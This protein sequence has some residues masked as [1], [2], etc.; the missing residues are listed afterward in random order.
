MKSIKR[1][2]HP[3]FSNTKKLCLPLCPPNIKSTYQ[4]H[5]WGNKIQQIQLNTNKKYSYETNKI[6]FYSYKI[7]KFYNHNTIF[8]PTSHNT[9]ISTALRSLR[10]IDSDRFISK[11]D[12]DIIDYHGIF[13]NNPTNINK[14]LKL[15]NYCETKREKDILTSALFGI[16]SNYGDSIYIANDF[17][18]ISDNI[19][20]VANYPDLV[21]AREIEKCRNIAYSLIYGNY[22]LLLDKNIYFEGEANIKYIPVIIHENEQDYQLCLTYN[23]TRSSTKC[24]TNI[25]KYLSLLGKPLLKEIQF[26]PKDTMAEYFYH[27]DCILN[28]TTNDKYQHFNSMDDFWKNYKKNG[29]IAVEINGLDDL[30]Y[31]KNKLNNIFKNIIN[32]KKEDDLLCANMIMMENGFVGSSN[33]S[34]KN[35]FEFNNTLF[36]EH[37]STGG[38]GAH[39]CCSNVITKNNEISVDDWINFSRNLNIEIDSQLLNGVKDE[40][41][42]IKIAYKDIL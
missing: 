42:R 36:F 11:I 1:F 7:S 23:S 31:S 2:Y 10:N 40:I 24:I 9:P 18:N 4:T 22:P 39:K 25:N 19:I 15:I 16:I 34:N 20:I 38:G 6:N 27:F 21:S 14:L 35:S 3:G 30:E 37:P 26:S 29:T 13:I 12:N 33:L 32:V 17:L 5:V 28:F 41:K 8:I